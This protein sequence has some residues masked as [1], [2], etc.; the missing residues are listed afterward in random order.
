MC[1]ATGQTVPTAEPSLEEPLDG[2]KAEYHD[3]LPV[4]RHVP[5][6]PELYP[7]DPDAYEPLDH[8]YQRQNED[9]RMLEREIDG[10]SAVRKT[11][12]A[13][14]LTDNEDGCAKFV[15][16]HH[17]ISFYVICGFHYK[18][19]RIAVTA[20]PV[21]HE[22]NRAEESDDWSEEEIEMVEQ[23][24]ERHFNKRSSKNVYR[25]EIHNEFH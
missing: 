24:N 16:D 2:R 20:W 12:Y 7:R 4:D 10:F 13:G 9:E 21:L 14:K 5:F 19:Y 1:S 23:F 17:G 11:I 25:R 15:Y 6:T 18:G 8:F 3:V 22:R